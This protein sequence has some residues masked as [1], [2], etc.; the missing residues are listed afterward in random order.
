MVQNHSRFI[1]SFNTDNSSPLDPRNQSISSFPFV[2]QTV[3][4]APS[5]LSEVPQRHWSVNSYPQRPYL[6]N[7]KVSNINFLPQNPSAIPKN[8]NHSSLLD[9]NNANHRLFSNVD[10][11][12]ENFLTQDI[13]QNNGVA[14]TT[15]NYNLN[16]DNGRKLLSPA[17]PII[18]PNNNNNRNILNSNILKN[19]PIISRVV[20]FECADLD[21]LA[22]TIKNFPNN[23]EISSYKIVRLL[24]TP[25]MVVGWF[26]TRKIAL[27]IQQLMLMFLSTTGMALAYKTIDDENTLNLIISEPEFKFLE[28]SYA[29]IYIYH[30]I[31]S[32]FELS[33][34]QDCYMHLSKFGCLNE[35]HQLDNS[36]SVYKCTFYDIRAAFEAKKVSNITVKDSKFVIYATLIEVYEQMN[37]K[38]SNGLNRSLSLQTDVRSRRMSIWLNTPESFIEPSSVN[39]CANNI[40]M[41]AT[42]DEWRKYQQL[43]HRRLASLPFGTPSI[44]EENKI[45]IENI[46]TGIDNRKTL[47]IRNIPNKIKH[48]ELEEFVNTYVLILK[49]IATL[50]MLSFHSLIQNISSNFIKRELVRSGINSILIRFVS[51]HML[52]FKVKKSS[53]RNLD[54]PKSWNKVQNT[55]LE[56][57]TLVAL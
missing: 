7:E 40:L 26:D 19:G 31:L 48:Q 18:S 9:S 25:L 24:G 5:L 12:F 17:M 2:S 43:K 37:V 28:N 16:I 15:T 35:F 4:Q 29:T 1:P 50:D 32:G 10:F 13:A 56:F 20:L 14:A 11:G 42:Q 52:R 41:N 34:E 55:S 27:H 46:E 30:N 33:F 53:S 3:H 57:T 49:T 38:R 22:E 39:T 44:P 23:S 47:M 36:P 21:S 6:A 51:W 54:I 8:M 45:V